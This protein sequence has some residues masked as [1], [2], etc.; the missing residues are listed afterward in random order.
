MPSRDY[1]SIDYVRQ[2]FEYRDGKLFWKTRPV[3]H[4]ADQRIC[5]SCNTKF[6]GQEA[7]SYSI[8]N[9]P[10]PRCVVNVAG[11]LYP[12]PT[13]VWALHHGEWRLGLDHENRNSLDDRIENLR[14]ATVS[15]NGANM[16]KP[17]HNTSGFKGVVYEGWR[18]KTTR[19]WRAQIKV[20]QKTMNL[21][22]FSTPEEAQATYMEA[23]KKHFGEFSCK[24]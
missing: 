11:R 18:K 17:R 19:K 3:E 2:L 14:P 12:R 23:A 16:K 13:I 10:S 21:G 9:R 8:E 20:R 4:F 15:Q 6:A 1:P 22:R 5:D 7:G 24:G